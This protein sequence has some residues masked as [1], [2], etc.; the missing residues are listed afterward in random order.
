MNCD[1]VKA[2]ITLYAY[3]ELGDDARFELEQHVGRCAG[4]AAELKAVT[5]FKTTMSAVPVLEPT[6]SLLAAARMRLQEALETAEQERGWRRWFFDPA[7]W[8][9]QIKFSPALATALL[10]I[11]FAAG[12]L[13]G[14]RLSNPVT[15]PGVVKL[16]GDG[17]N[18]SEASVAR[19]SD[20]SQ[21]PGTNKVEIK[22]DTIVP[23]KVEGDLNDSRIQQLLLFAARSNYN[24]GTRMDSVN[25]LTKNP[26]DSKVREALKAA[27]RYDSNAG[28]RIKALEALGPFVK[29]DVSV[30]DVVIEALLHDSNPGVRTEALMML[31]PVKADGTVRL[32]LQHLAQN[33]KDPSIRQ[34]ARTVLATIPDI[35]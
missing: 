10:I 30:R 33:D 12:S 13:A 20:I 31:N 15:G 32:A 26:D 1:W 24:P 3:D 5:A 21:L 28:V 29:D 18:L 4:C 14:F 27:L 23:E 22:Y 34:Q 8:L 25:L 35:D 9:R 7:A 19:I 2:N 11:G 17:S 6:P 16:V